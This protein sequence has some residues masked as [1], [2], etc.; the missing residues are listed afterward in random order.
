MLNQTSS[1]QLFWIRKLWVGHCRFWQP[2]V[3]VRALKPLFLKL[4]PDNSHT[5][6]DNDWTETES[7][8]GHCR[9]WQPFVLV[10]T[11][12]YEIRLSETGPWSPKLRFFINTF[13]LKWHETDGCLKEKSFDTCYDKPSRTFECYFSLTIWV[14]QQPISAFSYLLIESMPI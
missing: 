7:W 14:V 8:V 9:C 11:P 2:F 4:A 13:L 10:Q 5:Q 12:S 6:T 3:Y 1:N